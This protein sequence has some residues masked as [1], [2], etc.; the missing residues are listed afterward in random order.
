MSPEGFVGEVGWLIFSVGW[1]GL[2]LIF[3]WLN[4]NAFFPPS[5]CFGPHPGY[6][7]EVVGSDRRGQAAIMWARLP[8]PQRASWCYKLLKSDFGFSI[9]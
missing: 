7:E 4:T 2:D 6:Q 9:Y 1:V 5:C 3:P 8:P